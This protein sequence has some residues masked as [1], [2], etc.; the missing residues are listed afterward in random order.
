MNFYRYAPSIALAMLGLTALSQAYA[1]PFPAATSLIASGSFKA[2]NSFYSDAFTLTSSQSLTFFTSSFASGGFLPVLTL[3]NSTSGKPVDFSNSGLSDVLI[4]DLLTS[5]SYIL[6]LTEYPNE[7]VGNL[8]DGFLFSSD[9]TATGD[10]CGGSVMGK[11]FI[12]STTCS[13]T[14]LGN[15]YSLSVTATSPPAVTPEPSSL[16]LMLGPTAAMVAAFRRRRVTA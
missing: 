13:A 14:A 11:S 7:A 16:V 8:G 9:P 4:T 6:Y 3:F 10:L 15:N 12:N 1:D 2:D 5:G